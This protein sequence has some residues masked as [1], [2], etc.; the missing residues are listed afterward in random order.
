MKRQEWML[1][2]TRDDPLGGLFSGKKEKEPA[3]KAPK[4]S[5]RELNPYYKE[6]GSGLP[7][8]AELLTRGRFAKPT[9]LNTETKD[10]TMNKLVARKVRAEIA[11]DD[12]LAADIE[13]QI[14]R[15]TTPHESTPGPTNDIQKLV[16]EERQSYQRGYDREI[17][18]KISKQGRFSNIEDFSDAFHAGDR[19]PSNRDAIQEEKK[20]ATMRNQLKL[21]KIQTQ[22]ELCFESTTINMSLVLAIGNLV[23]L[24]LPHT[25]C[26]DPFHCRITPIQHASSFLQCDD[27]TW[28][29]VRNFK[30]CLLQLAATIN[31][32]VVFLET[33]NR[34]DGPFHTHID[35]IFLKQNTTDPKSYFRKALMECDEE[36]SSNK[37]VIDTAEKGGLRKSIPRD[38]AYC[39]ADFRLDQGFAHVIEDSRRVRYDFLLDLAANLMGLQRHQWKGQGASMDGKFRK[40]YE[41]FDWTAM[42]HQ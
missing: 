14:K 41:P 38:F 10:E 16:M 6:G 24:S 1:E 26:I 28:D 40:L 5:T 34:P 27:D 19:R 9:D 39:Y 42:L 20:R 12:E 2:G 25:D 15:S 8:G 11:G 22:C 32:T 3:S 7:P 4:V 30:K 21:E 31:R 17:A 29:E 37:R 36:W 35:A 13:A 18:Q 33:A 23:Y